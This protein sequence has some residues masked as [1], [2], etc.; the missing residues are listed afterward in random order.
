MNGSIV[1]DIK[2]T[3]DEGEK[4]GGELNGKSQKRNGKV[5]NGEQDV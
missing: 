2:C 5:K 4:W 3:N 1:H